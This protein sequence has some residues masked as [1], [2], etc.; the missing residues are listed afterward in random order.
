MS[1]WAEIKHALNSTL[2]TTDFKPLN[3]IVMQTKDLAASDYLYK[4]INNNEVSKDLAANNNSYIT[5]ATLTMHRNGSARIKFDMKAS[6]ARGGVRI[7]TSAEIVNV[8]AIE[9]MVSDWVACSADISFSKG[10]TVQISF[11]NGTR[12]TPTIKVKNMGVY[13]VELDITGVSVQIP[14]T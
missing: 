10:D 12:F 11:Y 4:V 6:Q 3:E 1:I 9:S 14:T 13:A 8:G 7:A 2:G 5:I